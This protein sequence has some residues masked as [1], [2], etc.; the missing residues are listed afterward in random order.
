MS[1]PKAEAIQRFHENALNHIEIFDKVLNDYPKTQ[2]FA[3]VSTKN[4]NVFSFVPKHLERFAADEARLGTIN[5][6]RF[7]EPSHV[8]LMRKSITMLEDLSPRYQLE[9]SNDMVDLDCI[10]KTADY[11]HFYKPPETQDYLY[12][13]DTIVTYAKTHKSQW[14]DRADRLQKQVVMGFTTQATHE[15]NAYKNEYAGERTY[16]SL[17]DLG[18]RMENRRPCITL[19]DTPI[20]SKTVIWDWI[21]NQ[22]LDPDDAKNKNTIIDKVND[23]ALNVLNIGGIIENAI[24]ITVDKHQKEIATLNTLTLQAINGVL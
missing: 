9:M 20:Q 13:I 6:P 11:K 3:I 21:E 14:L 7:G 12:V 24:L 23:L 19:N 2:T 1:N 5:R 15:L 8:Q 18:F 17:G 22:G 4:P 16:Q 10:I